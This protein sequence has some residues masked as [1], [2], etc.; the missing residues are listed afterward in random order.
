MVLVY[1][2]A[3]ETGE[4]FEK[5]LFTWKK[6]PTGSR[7]NATC[8]YNGNKTAIAYRWCRMNMANRTQYWDD[9]HDENCS[10]LETDKSIDQLVKVIEN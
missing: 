5:G 6:T 8:P 10:R 4:K 3:S 9:V 7:A 1:C 2:G